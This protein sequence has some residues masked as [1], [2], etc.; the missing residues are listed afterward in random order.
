MNTTL[1]SMKRD[2]TNFQSLRNQINDSYFNLKRVKCGQ[3]VLSL[4]QKNH[5]FENQQTLPIFSDP[6]LREDLNTYLDIVTDY[7]S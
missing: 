5:L 4:E 6:A 7:T 2:P 3:G 1:T